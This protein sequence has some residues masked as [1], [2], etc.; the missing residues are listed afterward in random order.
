RRRRCVEAAVRGGGGA[1]RRRC[2]EAAVRGGGGARAAAAPR[3]SP[4]A[5]RLLG[6]ADREDI[7]MPLRPDDLARAAHRTPGLDAHHPWVR[8]DLH[9]Y[10]PESG[11]LR[12]RRTGRRLDRPDEALNACRA[13][14]GL[15]LGTP[16]ARPRA[17]AHG[18]QPLFRVPLFVEDRDP[19]I[20]ALARRGI[21]VG[22]LY[23]PPLDD[24]AGP[25]FTD[26][27][28]GPRGG[29]PV[30]A[31]RAARGPAAGTD[32][33]RGAGAVRGPPGAGRDADCASPFG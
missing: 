8:V 1:W 26:P 12:L 30:R 14:T 5:I 22:Y 7:R 23:G 29:P 15:L 2:V 20:A 17:G 28:A 33:D 19:A 31:A 6:L 3:R 24:Y 27:L 16:W 11:P 21:A 18:T 4:A 13:G 10:R 32:G 9:G 25:E